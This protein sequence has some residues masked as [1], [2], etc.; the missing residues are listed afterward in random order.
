MPGARFRPCY[1]AV[2]AQGA[3]IRGHL[4][5]RGIGRNIMRP[6]C[7]HPLR[8][9]LIAGAAV[10]VAAQPG[11]AQT[12]GSPATSGRT[13]ASDI[14]PQSGFRLPLRPRE[15]LDEA[16]KRIYDRAVTPGASL[17]GLQGP[18]GVQLYSPKAAE[19]HS[20][21]NRYLRFQAGISPR[22]REIA[23]LITAR[24]MDSQ[25][26]WMA[27]EPEALK[28]GVPAAVIDVI[29][30]RKPLDGLDKTDAI[31]IT[32]GREIWRDHKVASQTFAA[33]KEI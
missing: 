7:M 21:L 31:V 30:R 16:G 8:L 27:H 4:R 1:N 13:M 2:P 22:I 28:E 20:S 33:A 29:K 32:L 23:I 25:F 3:A 11:L 24:E 17:V 5:G 15:E 19:H 26:E 12:G 18:A 14:D 6:L 9:L 10:M